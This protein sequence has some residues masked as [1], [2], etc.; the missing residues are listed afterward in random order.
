[1]PA[2]LY[3]SAIVLSLII[4]GS[5]RS[6]SKTNTHA[7][8]PSGAQATQTRP[9]AAKPDYSKEAFISEE[10]LTKVTFENDGTGSREAMERVRIQSDAGVQHFSVISFPYE[11]AAQTLTIDYVRVRK[12]DGTVIETPPDSFQDMPAEIT[13][14]APFYSDLRE[15]QVAVRG[16]SVGDVLETLAH[17][18]IT[19]PLAPGQF[20]FSFNFSHDVVCLR[21]QLQVSVPRER[22]VKWSSAPYQPSITDGRSRRVFTWNFSQLESKTADQQKKEQELQL[23]QTS[24]GKLPPAD[25]QISSFQSWTE[26]AAWYDALQRDRVKPDA[27]V[28][29]KAAELTNGLTDDDAKTRA[30]YDYVS[31]QFRYIGVAFGIGRYQPHTASEILMNQYGDCKDKHTLLASLLEAAGVRAYPALINS[32]HAIDLDVPSPAQFD[33]VITAVQEPKGLEWL[34]STPEVAPYGYLLS[35]LQ[36]KNALLIEDGRP[37]SLVSTPTE[38][39]NGLT[40]FRIDATLHED[41]TLVGKVERTESG[42]DSEVILRAAF[43]QVPMTQWKTLVQRISYAT[44]FSGDVS[45]VSVSAPAKIDQ[46]LTFSY[47]YTRKDFPQWSE[48]RLA[49]ALPPVITPPGDEVPSHPLLLGQPGEELRY[50]SRLVLPSGYTPQLPAPVALHEEFA[51]YQAS[52]TLNDGALVAQRTLRLKMREV[53]TKDFDAYKKF[54]KTIGDDYDLYVGLMQTHITMASYQ[55]AIWLLPYSSDSAAARAYEDARDDY[56]RHDLDGE[57]ASLKRAVEIDPKFTRAWLWM[58]DIYAFERKQDQAIAALRSAVA[59]DPKQPLAYKGLGFHL[60]S[61]GKFEEAASVWKH[62][63]ELAPGDSDGP[64]YLGQAL[65]SAKR[66]AEAAKAFGDAV[67]LSSKDAGLFVEL[68]SARLQA[69]DETN[70]MVAYRKALELDSSALLLNNIG[71]ALADANKQLPLALVY[72]QKAVLQE[73]QAAGKVQLAGLNTQDLAHTTALSAYWDTLGW[74]YFQ[75]GKLDQAEKYLNAAWALSQAPDM[76]DHL[77]QVYEKEH[78]KKEAVHMFRVALSTSRDREFTSKINDHLVQLGAGMDTN[79]L[80]F[81]GSGELSQARTFPVSGLQSDTGAAEFFLL[82]GSGGKV[83]DAKFISGADELKDA[84]KSLTSINFNVS[85][86]DSGPERLVRRGFLICRPTTHC[87]FVLQPPSY[88]RV[89]N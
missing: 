64:E 31:T 67:K 6:Q 15:K 37:A 29:A 71:Y 32:T 25:V 70:A 55:A 8:K 50:V 18:Q 33:H 26:V 5:A 53:P 28:R 86:P 69:G 2:R 61:A 47:T 66:Y 16:L 62:L 41:G 49:V 27:A 38:P 7:E 36:D 19:K 74:V 14:E 89:I 45:D 20:W 21:E 40:T 42:D 13:R 30:I 48:H 34:D 65:S 4:V 59:N 43:R 17:W 44:G 35:V 11:S 81:D 46:P 57:T 82:L 68:G 12:P 72:A 51:D 63:I 22:A 54:C 76:A 78:R 3:L 85:M 84:G 83:E 75:M 10:S 1:M 77:A 79:P 24:V 88:V 60:M 80:E 87:M 73:E 23:Y 9:P 52:Y 56:N 39:A 58:A